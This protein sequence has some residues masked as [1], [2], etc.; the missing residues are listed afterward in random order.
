MCAITGYEKTVIQPLREM[1]SSATLEADRKTA[2]DLLSRASTRQK[3]AQAGSSD[4]NARYIPANQVASLYA[5]GES[6]PLAAGDPF[7]GCYRFAWPLRVTIALGFGIDLIKTCHWT[8]HL[9]GWAVKAF[10]DG[11]KA[12]ALRKEVMRRVHQLANPPHLSLAEQVVAKSEA[13]AAAD[14]AASV[15]EGV[16][17]NRAS[18]KRPMREEAAVEHQTASG[19]MPV[20]GHSEDDVVILERNQATIVLDDGS[21]DDDDVRIDVGDVAAQPALWYPSPRHHGCIKLTA[22]HL[23]EVSNVKST[24]S[25]DV[26]ELALREW[27]Y[28]LDPYSRKQTSSTTLRLGPLEQNRMQR[29]FKAVSATTI[30]RS[31]AVIS[32]KTNYK[33][34]KLK[35]EFQ[36]GGSPLGKHYVSLSVYLPGQRHFGTL[37]VCVPVDA[38][39]LAS[40]GTNG[41]VYW[42]DFVEG[43]SAPPPR[44]LRSL[45]AWLQAWYDL[46]QEDAWF[47]GRF[48]LEYGVSSI[49][50]TK[51]DILPLPGAS[52]L[53]RGSS[54]DCAFW[55]LV[56]YTCH[57]PPQ[58]RREH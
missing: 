13:A 6:R 17:A 22:K 4:G 5:I 1:T 28:L 42:V 18:R 51:A 48:L 31:E 40:F 41:T 45:L 27:E 19:Q 11:A 3:T 56:S 57:P 47:R 54:R 43:S 15:T 34:E 23:E 32:L 53:Q 16:G 21:G 58:L 55:S 25:S 26:L 9:Q 50:L 24:V 12:D 29:H 8:S 10:N 36:C 39:M 2:H 30:P 7:H 49:D 46:A 37:V 44:L 14:Q 35:A 52:G 20:A 33:I 38:Q